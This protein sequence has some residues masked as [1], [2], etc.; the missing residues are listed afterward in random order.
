MVARAPRLTQPRR[1]GPLISRR[2]VLKAGV[3]G[4]VAVA[5]GAA[6]EQL[7]QAGLALLPVRAPEPS[8]AERRAFRSRPD[9]TPPVVSTA[10]R[11]G[12]SSTAGLVFLT[13]DNGAPP[14]GP[15]IVTP[16]GEPVWVHP[17]PDHQ[18]ANLR[19]ATYRGEPVLTWWEGE[20]TK[21]GIGHGECVV[22]DSSYREV[23]RVQAANGLEADLHEFVIG[24]GD[25]GFL[26]A[27]RVV[28]ATVPAASGALSPTV[29]P[30]LE[31]IIQEVDLQ[32]GELR[33]EWHS[34]PA[35]DPSESFAAPPTDGSPYDYLHANSI[36]I[37]GDSLLLSARHTCAIYRIDRRTGAIEWRLG[38]RQ[39]DIAV[40]AEA[41]FWWQ[42]DVRRRSDGTISIFDNGA[43]G[44]TT[45]NEPRSR[46]LVL[47]LDS[48]SATARL[49]G[50][51][52]HP[53]G[54][55]TTSQGSFEVMDDG[56]A[57]MGWGST[58]RYTRFDPTGAVE[59]DG[60]FAAAVQSYRAILQPWVGRPTDPPDVVV[61]R[62]TPSP[63]LYVSWN[64]ATNVARWEALDPDDTSRAVVAAARPSG[65][66]TILRVRGAL[67][68]PGG[69]LVVRALDA[70]GTEIG[71]SR[72]VDLG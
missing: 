51:F 33:F 61:D 46:G 9:L 40:P 4:A 21:A 29:G 71:R 7:A 56:G 12:L 49:V 8:P 23:A 13:P 60:S 18:V 69:S 37:D 20:I 17:V 45:P 1:S 48:A 38:G 15:L 59:L 58:P 70:T 24:P 55:L 43:N 22:V 35:I 54:V 28:T 36:D 42:H 25:T 27:T 26:L 63:T 57:F 66:E 64:G 32:T 31:G 3:A 47:A 67:G 72:P 2:Q 30:V 5:A 62:S 50:S 16:G 6:F 41:Q 14:D 53:D 44:A 10:S 52:I 11:L 19:P 68:R 65:F 39:S 34:L